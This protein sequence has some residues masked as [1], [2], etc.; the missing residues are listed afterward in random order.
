[1]MRHFTTTLI[2]IAL[3]L[4]VFAAGTAA[5]DDGVGSD[6]ARGRAQLTLSDFSFS[7][8]GQVDVIQQR[9]GRF[10]IEITGGVGPSTSVCPQG[11]CSNLHGVPATVE[12]IKMQLDLRIVGLPETPNLYEAQGRAQGRV[13]WDLNGD[14]SFDV[15]LRWH[16]TV[17]A[18]VH[19]EG[20]RYWDLNFES[21]VITGTTPDMPGMQVVI[22]HTSAG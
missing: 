21:L 18:T 7:H 13:G 9:D 19:L 10:K 22:D 5:P 14:G 15:V 17:E 11:P 1:M 8:L 12:D 20:G 16:G 6:P 4:S 2:A 3:S